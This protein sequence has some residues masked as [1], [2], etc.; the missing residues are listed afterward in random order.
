MT[1]SLVRCILTAQSLCCSLY[2][3]RFVW[4]HKLPASDL[5][6]GKTSHTYILSHCHSA[7]L[8]SAES[9]LGGKGKALSVYVSSPRPPSW[10]CS[11]TN[12]A[13]GIASNIFVGNTHSVFFVVD[14]SMLCTLARHI[15]SCTSPRCVPGRPR[16]PF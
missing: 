6:G 11:V 9:S 12:S 5:V 2:S 1:P 7:E 16:A 15:V 4:R 8:C 13:G 14:P 10:L 3:H